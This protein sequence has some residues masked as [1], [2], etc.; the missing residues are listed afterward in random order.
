MPFHATFRVRS[1]AKS[2]LFGA[3]YFLNFLCLWEGFILVMTRTC[4]S[5]EN[6]WFLSHIHF[7]AYSIRNLQFYVTFP[8][9]FEILE[10]KNLHYMMKFY[11]PPL[12]IFTFRR[13]TLYI[14]STYGNPSK[15]SEFLHSDTLQHALSNESTFRVPSQV[16]FWVSTNRK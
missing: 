5:T 10:A 14:L 1:L 11:S 16:T 6:M 13:K 3:R 12:H 2:S 15:F 7:K 8:N 9:I 4:I